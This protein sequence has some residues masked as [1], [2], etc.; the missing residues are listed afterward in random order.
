M[1]P[2]V[3]LVLG[4][5]RPFWR[6]VVELE[7]VL[8]LHGYGALPT[9]WM[10]ADPAIPTLTGWAGGPHAA[11][12]AGTSREALQDIAV[13]SLAD[14]LGAPAAD[15]ASQL[16]SCH[17][18]DCSADPLSRGAYTYVGVGGSEAHLTLAAPVATL[19]RVRSRTRTSTSFRP[20]DSVYAP[21][22]RSRYWKKRTRW[23]E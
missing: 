17:Y 5:R 12:L 3:K 19:G 18:H 7:G 2:V 6:D 4:F 15:V 14:A 22:A 8:F 1:G 13:C 20:F 9:W 23:D 21:H 10:P 16:E 11:R